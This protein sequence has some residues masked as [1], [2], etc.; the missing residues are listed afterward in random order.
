[1]LAVEVS[2]GVLGLN[3]LAFYNEFLACGNSLTATL[4]RRDPTASYAGA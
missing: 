1:L 2:R 3:T 4:F